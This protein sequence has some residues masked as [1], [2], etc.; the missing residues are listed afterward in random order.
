MI[1]SFAWSSLSEGVFLGPENRYDTHWKCLQT[2]DLIVVMSTGGGEMTLGRGGSISHSG[3]NFRYNGNYYHPALKGWD[4][5][6][7]ERIDYV[8]CEPDNF[9]DEIHRIEIKGKIKGIG[10]CLTGA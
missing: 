5:M 7:A 6:R 2:E 9:G 10:R 3:L 1:S 4:E 8:A